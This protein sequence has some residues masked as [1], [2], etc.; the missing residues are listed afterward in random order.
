M[1]NYVLIA[2]VLI[3]LF[4]A[5]LNSTFNEIQASLRFSLPYLALPPPSLLPPFLPPP[6][7]LP[8]SPE[9]L[10]FFLPPS[11]PLNFSLSHFCK[12]YNYRIL[13]LEIISGFGQHWRSGLIGNA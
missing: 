10:P 11:L 4:I 7:S 3:N 5:S 2:V 6:S 9:S 8:P 12:Y 13:S 1:S